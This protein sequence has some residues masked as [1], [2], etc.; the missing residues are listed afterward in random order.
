M[1]DPSES[2]L[3]NE[4]E[5]LRAE[6]ARLKAAECQRDQAEAALRESERRYRHLVD[7]A[8]DILYRADKGGHFTY[9]NP[10][11]VRLMGY[12]AEEI[13]GRLYLDLIHPDY[14]REAKKLYVRQIKEQIP[15]TYFEYPAV[16]KDGSLLWL[17]QNVQLV[18]ERGEV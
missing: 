17:G 4:L 7:H 6:N 1:Q 10:A 12:S 16:R 8:N 5:R 2:A 14:R 11:A 13:L 9:F 18:V 15:N 3:R